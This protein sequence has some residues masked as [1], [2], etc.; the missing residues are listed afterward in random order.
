MKVINKTTKY[1]TAFQVFFSHW[2]KFKYLPEF[3]QGKLYNTEKD[4]TV[5]LKRSRESKQTWY[6]LALVSQIY[7]MYWKPVFQ[8][9]LNLLQQTKKQ[10]RLWTKMSL[11]SKTKNLNNESYFPSCL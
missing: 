4:Y 2:K 9:I 8:I 10:S 5:F 3:S 7:P 11:F 6:I 1:A